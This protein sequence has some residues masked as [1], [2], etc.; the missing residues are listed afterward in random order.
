MKRKISVPEILLFFRQ[1]MILINKT[2]RKESFIAG[3]NRTRH[4]FVIF[5]AGFLTLTLSLNAFGQ[6]SKPYHKLKIGDQIPDVKCTSLVNCSESSLKLSDFKGKLLII[7]FWST[8]CGSCVEVLPG[9]EQTQRKFTGRVQILPVTFDSQARVIKFMQRSRYL[10][11]YKIPSVTDDKV[12]TRLFPH[13]I[14]PHEVW[15]DQK[16]KVIAFTDAQYVNEKIIDAVLRGDLSVLSEKKDLPNFSPD[17]SLV[18]LN[19]N[20]AEFEH[21]KMD[22]SYSTILPYIPGLPSF[23]KSKD[24]SVHNVSRQLIINCSVL[25]MYL[26]AYRE[27]GL[28]A[29]RIFIEAKDPSKYIYDKDKAYLDQWSRSNSFCYESVMP[30]FVNDSVRRQVLIQD[31]DR[32]LNLDG[33]MQKRRI[34]C[35][36]LSRTDST[37]GLLKTDGGK[38]I[39]TLHKPGA[40]K[41]MH[42]SHLDNIVWELNQLP[43][44]L[45]AFD[46]TGYHG[47][48]DMVLNFSSFENLNDV[49]AAIKP[50]GLDLQESWREIEVFVLSDSPDKKPI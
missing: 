15:I 41:I 14:I 18:Q 42:N 27:G 25:E 22:F 20:I 17:S 44:G 26:S 4:R 6:E 49:R 1:V 33:R 34:K 2:F 40:I 21:Q 3:N 16:G 37:S 43:H 31:L 23:M 28:P 30:L 8:S 10:E 12:L 29:S 7:D 45:P 47:A 19:R 39:Y 46:E 36:I 48:V 11:G 32:V 13:A 9:M 38:G 24:D 5:T 35:L 50:Y